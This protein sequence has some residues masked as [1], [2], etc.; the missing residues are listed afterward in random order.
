ME[1]H[2][3]RWS[4]TRVTHASLRNSASVEFQGK[5]VLSLWDAQRCSTHPSIRW[6]H[7]E[8]LC[9]MRNFL[10]THLQEPELF[11]GSW[12]THFVRDPSR[13][14]ETPT[15]NFYEEIYEWRWYQNGLRIALPEE[16]REEYLKRLY[17]QTPLWLVVMSRSL[18]NPEEQDDRKKRGVDQ[19]APTHVHHTHCVPMQLGTTADWRYNDHRDWLWEARQMARVRWGTR[20]KGFFSEKIPHYQIEQSARNHMECDQVQRVPEKL[21]SSCHQTSN[22]Q[23][24]SWVWKSLWDSFPEL[25][26]VDLAEAHVTR[27]SV[28]L[29]I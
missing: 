4:G 24:Y 22:N 14:I 25:Y 2:P 21:S 11:F 20:Y 5:G 19:S 15:W 10:Q 23:P 1:Q 7:R 3:G 26:C 6:H 27:E 8:I 16:S 29:R 12:V 13:H 28:S 9:P 18:R 17:K